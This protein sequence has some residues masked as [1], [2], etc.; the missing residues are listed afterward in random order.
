MID[1]NIPLEEI[2][3]RR[4][5]MEELNELLGRCECENDRDDV[6]ISPQLLKEAIDKTKLLETV[7]RSDI[8]RLFKIGYPKAA[9]LFEMM[10]NKERKAW[11]LAKTRLPASLCRKKEGVH[12]PARSRRRTRR[13][14][15]ETQRRAMYRKS[16]DKGLAW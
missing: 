15:G 4:G 5:T 3:K 12:C 1:K 11:P 8:Q 16:V 13:E 9:K 7:T 2:A 14:R 6:S 10:A